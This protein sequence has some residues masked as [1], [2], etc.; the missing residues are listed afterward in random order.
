MRP[1]M[2]KLVDALIAADGE[3]VPFIRDF[4]FAFNYDLEPQ[5]Q[6][7]AFQGSCPILGEGE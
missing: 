1:E 6:L 7:L 5:L 4:H 2:Q 3:I